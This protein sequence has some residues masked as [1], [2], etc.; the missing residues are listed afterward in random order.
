MINRQINTPLLDLAPAK[1]AI[2]CEQDHLF[3]LWGAEGA[4]AA[5]KDTH[6]VSKAAGPLSPPHIHP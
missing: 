6:L 5:D 2:G 1:F 3:C 4:P